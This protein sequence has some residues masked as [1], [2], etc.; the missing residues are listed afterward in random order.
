MMP[1]EAFSNH[2]IPTIKNKLL[3]FNITDYIILILTIRI[4]RLNAGE[5]LVKNNK[6]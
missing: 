4:P 1:G 6:Y 5:F 2:P 3:V